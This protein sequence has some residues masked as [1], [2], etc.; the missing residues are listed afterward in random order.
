MAPL[1]TR[2]SL[3]SKRFSLTVR[4]PRAKALPPDREATYAPVLN[5][6]SAPRR[7]PSALVATSR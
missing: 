2:S 3:R 6:R 7:V 4:R 1:P 5:V